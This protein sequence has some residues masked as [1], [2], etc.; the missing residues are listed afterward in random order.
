[1]QKAFVCFLFYFVYNNAIAQNLVMNPSFEEYYQCPTGTYNVE[2]CKYVF[3]PNCANTSDLNCAYSPDYFNA[4]ASISSNANVPNTGFAYQTAKEGDAFVGIGIQLQ[5]QFDG[6]LVND[7]REFFQIKLSEILK[8][9]NHYTFS[10]Y[11]NRANKPYFNITINQLGLNFVTDS[12]IYGNTPLWHIMEADW[13]SNEYIMDTLG[14]QKLS[15]EYVAKGG[16]K[17]VIVG[18]FYPEDGFPYKEVNDSF[19]YQKAVYL[20]I[21]D[22]SVEKAPIHI[23]NV[24]TPNQD[25]V[26]DLWTTGGEVEEIHILNRWGNEVFSAGK[27]FNGWNGENKNGTP[28]SNGVYYYLLTEKIDKNKPQTHTG[29]ITLIR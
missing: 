9:G 24:L 10:F 6:K 27:D 14:W 17:W 19:P 22:F 28:C 4:C 25:G 21:D 16:E 29:F 23:P 13:V 26:N 3:N 18:N 11:V 20:F 8:E 12:V 5:Y 7:Y 1:M 2:D 15:G